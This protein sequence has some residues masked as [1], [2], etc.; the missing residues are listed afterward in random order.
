MLTR[1]AQGFYWVNMKHDVQTYVAACSMS[2]QTKYS[3]QKS[4]G[5][6][7][8]LPL[9]G[10]VWE[11]ISM[12]FITGLPSSNGF[13]VILVVVDRLS[14]HAYIGQLKVGFTASVVA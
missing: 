1:I 5:L 12:D 10:N 2:Q 11:D 3:T 7:Q 8:P 9:P 4:C 6:L 13:T 14:K